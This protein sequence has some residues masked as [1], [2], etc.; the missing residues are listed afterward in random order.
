MAEMLLVLAINDAG[1]PGSPTACGGDGVSHGMIDQVGLHTNSP[2]REAVEQAK[3]PVA[4]SIRSDLTIQ[5]IFATPCYHRTSALRNLNI[6]R[7]E[8]LGE[9]TPEAGN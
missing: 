9:N 7:P 6:P 3:T 1:E 8:E 5:G 4:Q 2:I